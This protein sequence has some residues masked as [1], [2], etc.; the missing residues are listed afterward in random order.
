M[1]SSGRPLHF[2]RRRGREKGTS[3]PSARHHS[4]SRAKGARGRCAAAA[5]DDPSDLIEMELLQ[6][7]ATMVCARVRERLFC[8]GKK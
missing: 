8:A 1:T 6:H 3:G 2:C 7:R 4:A 5:A